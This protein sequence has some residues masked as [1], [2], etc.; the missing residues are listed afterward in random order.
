MKA[1]VLP[2]ELLK[3]LKIVEMAAAK[4]STLPVLE[5]VKVEAVE[6]AGLLLY[7]TDLGVSMVAQVGARVEEAG[8]VCVPARVLKEFVAKVPDQ[9]ISLAT[10][11]PPEPPTDEDGEPDLDWKAPPP[12][13]ILLHGDEVDG[14]INGLP[15][16]EFPEIPEPGNE[17]VWTVDGATFVSHV[18]AVVNSAARDESR[19]VLTGVLFQLHPDG[20]RMVGCDGFRLAVIGEPLAPYQR[21]YGA[22]RWGASTPLVPDKVEN[23]DCAAWPYPQFIL[24]AETLA[25]FCQRVKADDQIQILHDRD[26]FSLVLAGKQTYMVTRELA[27]QYPQYEQIVP[28]GAPDLTVRAPIADLLNRVGLA[29]VISARA[30]DAVRISLQDGQLEI[31]GSAD[32]DK[33]EGGI[34]VEVSHNQGTDL[35]LPV[36][37]NGVYLRQ[38]LQGLK[39]I[40]PGS[41]FVNLDFRPGNTPVV[42]RSDEAGVYAHLIM[43]VNLPR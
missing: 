34:A 18:K 29:S 36:A 32:G 41:E 9:T 19:P 38:A 24:N 31:H 6:G 42:I 21:E 1:K 5:M 15:S 39:V 27:G 40:S 43:P 8:A 33:G 17:E 12:D 20:T 22:S 35:P 30:D 25:Q 16:V 7:A 23:E 11:P 37:L 4:L 3:G 26:L 28:T 2:S 10:P 13:T 14:K